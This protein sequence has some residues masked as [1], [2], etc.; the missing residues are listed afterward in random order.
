MNFNILCRDWTQFKRKYI[1]KQ[2]VIY[3]ST[4]INIL[5]NVI[6]NNDRDLRPRDTN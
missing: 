4:I 3:N 1:Y 6:L 5:G 2:Y